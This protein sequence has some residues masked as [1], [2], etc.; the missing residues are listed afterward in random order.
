M[1]LQIYKYPEWKETK[2][3]YIK[4]KKEFAE[5]WYQEISRRHWILFRD[6][7]IDLPMYDVDES[8]ELWKMSI[9]HLK[10]MMDFLKDNI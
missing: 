9:S 8:Y 5:L 3:W 1:K 7:T 4:I 10:D 6:K 2:I